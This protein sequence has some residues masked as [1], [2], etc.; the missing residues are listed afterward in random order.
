MIKEW[1]KIKAL[2]FSSLL[3]EEIPHISASLEG[4][5]QNISMLDKNN[6]IFPRNVWFSF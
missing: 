5:Q 2:I 4:F 3:R 6:T 1:K